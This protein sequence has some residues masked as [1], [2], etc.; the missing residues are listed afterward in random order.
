MFRIQTKGELRGTL[1]NCTFNVGR[2]TREQIIRYLFEDTKTHYGL[3]AGDRELRIG[4]SSG[5]NSKVVKFQMHDTRAGGVDKIDMNHLTAKFIGDLHD[6]QVMMSKDELAKRFAQNLKGLSFDDAKRLVE[7]IINNIH[8]PKAHLQGQEE[9]SGKPKEKKVPNF[10]QADNNDWQ[11]YLQEEKRQGMV[12]VAHVRY[13]AN[14]E[15]LARNNNAKY[16][17]H[18]ETIENDSRYGETESHYENQT[19]KPRDEIDGHSVS[20]DLNYRSGLSS[21]SNNSFGQ[22]IRVFRDLHLL[23]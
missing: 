7:T 5:V 13:G 14:G 16:G 2:E 19:K 22:Q 10:R 11:K 23:H 6:T 3:E 20:E 21:T 17:P 15:I 4:Q 8:G 1:G 12:D 9:K 18:G